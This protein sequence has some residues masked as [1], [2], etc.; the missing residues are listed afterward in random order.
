MDFKKRLSQLTNLK[1]HEDFKD[2]KNLSIQ[3]IGF[4]SSL[5]LNKKL[6]KLMNGVV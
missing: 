2:I 4:E 3:I 5:D 6:V 1:I